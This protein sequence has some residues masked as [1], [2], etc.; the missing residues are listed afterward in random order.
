M[1]FIGRKDEQVKMRG[2]RI[3]L[4]EV[5]NTLQTQT[6]IEAAVVIAKA[7]NSGEKE[8]VAYIVS[9]TAQNIADLRA[10]LSKTLPAYMLPAHFVQLEVLPLTPNGKVDKK[11]LPEPE[12]LGITG[13]EYVAPRNDTEE[14]LAAIWQEV[15]GHNHIGVKDN[16]FEVGGHSLK[17]TRL[18]SKIYNAFEV[19]LALKDLFNYAVLEEQAS[20]IEQSSKA[21]F[22]NIPL[23]NPQP[24]YALS[25]AQRRLWV[26]SQFEEGSIAYN[27]PGVYVLEG[28]LDEAAF[29]TAFDQLI[30]RHEILRTVFKENEQGDVQQYILSPE[31]AG[32][33]ITFQDLRKENCQP[34]DIKQLV[35]A[36]TQVPFNLSAGPLMRAVLYQLTDAKWLLSFTMHHIISDGWS[37]G[38]LV[39]ELSKLYNAQINGEQL[40]LTPLSIQYKD[41]AA[42]QQQQLA[43]GQLAA[44]RA[45][46]LQQFAAEPPVLDLPSD[47][48]RP[49]VKTYNGSH[50]QL[51]VNK[52][53]QE[54]LQQLS[55]R[56]GASIFMS[57]LAAVKV[58]LYRYTWQEDLV[59]GTPVAG[60]YHHQL[61]DQV[62]F[63]VNTLA[64]RSAIKRT[65][66][67]IHVLEQVKKTTL[68][69]YTH[70]AY[71]FDQLVDELQPERSLSH[72]PLFDVMVVL[73]EKETAAATIANGKLQHLTASPF[74]VEQ[75]LSKFDLTFSFTESEEGIIADLEYNTD[76]YAAWRIE[77]YLAHFVQLLTAIVKDPQAPVG[78]IRYTSPQEEQVLLEQ[79]N[80]AAIAYPRNK[81]IHE[82]FEAQA[83]QTP[84]QVAIV[85]GNTQ[86]TYRELNEKANQLAAC[87]RDLYQVKNEEPVG[88]ITERSI[89][90]AIGMLGILK[91]GAAYV[92]VDPAHPAERIQYMLEDAGIR[93]AVIT[94][95]TLKANLNISACEQV[96]IKDNDL[97]AQFPTA[98]LPLVN[99]AGSLVYVIY[100]S[101]STGKP[102]GVQVE[103][104]SLV[105]LCYWHNRSFK[106]TADSKATV[107]SSISFDAAGWEV[108]PYLL[109]G[110]ALY[111]L[112]DE[113]R[114]DLPALVAFIQEQKITHCF[115]PTVISEKL[116]DLAPG[117]LANVQVLTGGDAL[118]NTG[119]GHL[120]LVNNYGPTENTV[121]TTSINLHNSNDPALIPIGKPIDNTQVYILDED[122]Q[123]QPIGITGEICIAGDGLARGYLNQPVL[124]AGKFIAHPF[125]PG[126][127]LYRTGDTGRW[128]PDGNIAFTG[129]KDE[130]VKIRGYRIELGEIEHTLQNHPDIETAIVLAQSL[131]E[132]GPELVAYIVA[133]AAL[134]LAELR[135]YLG[136]TLP[137]YMLPAYVMQLEQLPL[138]AS[139]KVDR[140]KLPMPAG[141]AL[142]AG[143]TYVAPRN[144]TEQELVNIWQE[145]LGRDGIGIKDNFF[146][147]G[148]HSLKA[149]RLAS[150]LYKRFETKIALKDLFKHAVLEEQASLVLQAVKNA[151]VGIT[152][153]PEQAAYTLSSA[154]RRL[155]VLSQFEEGNLA[156]N[157]AGT[158][159]FEGNLDIPALTAA[160]NALIARHESLRTT[161][162]E[163]EQGEVKQYIAASADLSITYTDVRP[164]PDQAEKVAA[165]ILQLAATLFDLRTGPLLRAVLYQVADNKWVFSFVMHH[166]I[167]DGWSMSILIRELL[168]LYHA[169]TVGAA[170]PLLP[171]RIQ[172]K[173]YAAWQQSQ[174]SEAALEPH[175]H[176][177]LQQLSGELPLLDLPG[178]HAR[179]A[180]KTYNGAAVNMLLSKTLTHGLQSLVNEQ[181]GTLF[182]G[183][184]AAV[185][186]L[187]HRYTSQEDIIIGT[188]VAGRMHSDLEDQVGLYV[189]TLAIRNQF[190][191]T[192]SYRSLLEKVKQTTLGAYEH[193]VYPFDELVD[194]LPLRRDMSRSALFDVMVILQN[195]GGVIAEGTQLGDARIS[196]YETASSRFTKFDLTFNFVE[197]AE[198]LQATIEYNRDLY[199]Q[200]T[201][202]RL[203]HHLEQLL[204][205]II[206]HPDLPLNRLNYLGAAAQLQLLE[207]FNAT[208]VVYK[209]TGT[210]LQKFEEQAAKTPEQVAILFGET[211]LSYAALNEQANQL[212]DY[213][214]TQY[215]IQANDRI[216][217]QLDR[218]E[219]T[220]IAILAVLKSGGAYVLIDTEYPQERIDYIIAD[221]QCKVVI[222]ETE[223]AKFK[224]VA[225]Q[226]SAENVNTASQPGDLAYIIYTSRS[227]GKPKGVMITHSN[228]TAFINWSQQ[229][230]N[231][232]AFDVVFAATSIC[233]DLSV[234]EIFYPLSVGKPVRFLT[235]ALAIPQYLNTAEKIL[236]NTVPSVVGNLLSE[237]IDLSNVT[238]LNMAGEPIPPRYLDQLDA[239][240][241][242]I[243]NLYGPSEDTTYSTVYR[244]KKDGDIL[245]GKP[246][247]NTRIYIL[248]EALQLQPVGVAGEI[249]IAGD[250][251]AQG[252]LNQPELT[253]AKFIDNP[254]KPG[255]RLYRTGDLGRWLSDGN[256][257]FIGR[258]DEQAKIRGYRIELGEIENALQTQTSIESAV[259][260]AK[261]NSSGEKEIVAYIVSATTQN[262]ADLRAALSKTLPAYMLPAHFVQLEV[263]PLTPNGK[264]DKKQL[265]EPEGL[266]IT[267]VEYVAPRNITEE[268]LVAIWQQVL[269]RE[270]IGV[271]D[272]FFELGGHSLKITRLAS[273]LI[274]EF[275]VKVELK[276][277]FT[278]ATPEEQAQLIQRAQK[279]AYIHIAPADKKPYYAL[280]SAQRR[281]FFLHEFAPESTG[282]NMPTV[283][284][285]GKTVD[286]QRIISVLQQLIARHESIRTSFVKIDGIA[287]QQI[288]KQVPFELEEHNC[289]PEEFNAYV[290][291]FVRPFDV[292]K[293]PLLRSS[294]VNIAGIG[295]AW[296]VDMH[297]IISDGTS[298][299][300]LIDDFLQLYNGQPLPALQLQY[301]D[302]SEWQNSILES[303]AGE[304]QKQYWLSQFA[305]GIPRLNFPASRP[306]PATFTFE[307]AV[308]QFSLGAALTTQVRQYG[309]QH[310]GT[311]QMTLLAVLNVVLHKY[312]GQ[313]DIVI[314][315]GIAGRRHPEVERIVG[316]FVNT[317]AIRNY[318]QGDKPFEAFYG[319]VMNASIGAYENQD[320][321]FE[322]LLNML[323]VEREPSRNPIFDIAMVVQNF[324]EAKAAQ[325]GIIGAGSADDFK[326]MPS[327]K[328]SGTSK[329][330]MTWFVT[331]QDED[332]IIDLEYYSA[333]YDA[334]AIEQLVSH[335]RNTLQ[336]VMLQPAITLSGIN[337]LSAKEE[338]TLLQNFA[339]GPAGYYPS[340]S[341]LHELFEAQCQ[342][343]PDN[344]AVK[345]PADNFTYRELDEKAN[346]LA[347][348]LHHTVQLQPE[349]RVGILQTRSKELLVSIFGVL[350]AG[351]AYVPLD[352][353]Y[354]EER[355]IYML[356]DAG[357]DILLVEKNLIEF[358]N[359]IQWRCKGIKHLVCIDS[360]NIHREQGTI[361]NELMRKDLWDHVGDTATDAIT[362][363]GWMS[364]YTGEYLSELEM[365][366][367]A[368]NAYLKLKAHLHPDAK[369]LEIGCSSGLTMFQV[370]PQVASYH[371]TDLSSSILAYTQQ[372]VN[373][374]GLTNIRLSCLP[375]DE[376]DRLEDGDFD[377]V[378]INSVIQSFNGH[379]YLRDVLIKVISKIKDKGLLFLGDIQDEDKREA[380]ISDLTAFKQNHREEDY[381]TK[382]DWSSELFLSR[383]Y[384]S[385]LIPD[386]IGIVAA[387]YSDKVH[388]VANELTRYRFDALLHINKQQ[389]AQTT[390]K[391]KYQHD[392]KEI[393]AQP[394][395]TLP[396]SVKPD[397]L[398]Y[399]I[400]TSGSTGKPKG[401]MVEHRTVVNYIT[402]SKNTYL[403]EGPAHF[404]LFTS[405]SFD[406]T[407]TSIF[408]P[409]LTGNSI[410]VYDASLE[411]TDLLKLQMDRKNGVDVIKLTPSHI[412]LIENIGLRTTA[413]KSAIV[414]G[415]ELRDAHISIL[416][417]LDPEMEIYNEYGPTEATVGC[418]VWKV[419]GDF[420]QILIGK[421]ITNTSI[422]LMDNEHRIVPVGVI[423][424]ICIGGEC[425][426][427]GYLNKPAL[428]AEKFVTNPYNTK[429]RIYKTGDLGRWLP[430]GNIEF[431]GRKDDQVKIRGYR[432]ELGEIESVLQSHPEIDA[433]VVVA[434]FNSN[435]E[436]ELIA[437]ITARN[438]LQ[439]GAL[440][441]Y[442]SGL[443]PVY[444]LPGHYVQLDK[445]PLTT[446]GKV[447]RKRLPD[448]EGMGLSAG[449]EYVAPQTETE[450]KLVR[451]WE[452]VLGK[453][454]VGLKDN[455]FDLGGHSLKATRLASLI[456]REFDVKVPLK[457]L[458]T[459]IIL[460]QQANLIQHTRKTAF[461]A[462]SPVTEQEHYQLSSSQRRLWVLSLFEGGNAAYNMPG[463]YVFEGQ[464]NQDAL[465]YAFNALI[466]RHEILRTIFKED[467]DGDVRQY[468][469][470]PE[471]A[472]FTI[473]YYDV[474]QEGEE[475]LRERIQQEILKPFDL[476]AGPLL[477][478]ALYQVTDHK[479]IFTH[480]MH[481]IISDG[482]SMG[483]LIKELLQLYNAY[484]K[485]KDFPL[486][487]LRIQYKDY[488]AWQQAQLTG[489]SLQRHKG[490]WL[491]QF[492][493]ELP[494]LELPA[495]K[496]RPAVKTYNS[497]LVQQ[498][499]SKQ[500]N[501]GIKSLSQAQGATLFM[502]LLTLVKALLYRYT[503]Q[504]DIIIGTPIAG[505]DHIDLENQIGFYIN[506]LA[507][508]TRFKGTD[509]YQQLLEQVQQVTL[510]AYEHQMYP[511]DGLVDELHLQRDMS[512]SALFDVMV[513]LQNESDDRQDV[514]YV[515]GL[516]ISGYKGLVDIVN[517]FDLCF[518]FMEWEEELLLNL[519][520]NSDIYD[521]ETIARLGIHL[522]NLL[523]AVIEQPAAPIYQ[524]G[525]LQEKEKQQLLIS[526]NDTV[527][528]WSADNTVVELFEEQ[529]RQT[530][531]NI[532]LVF[533]DTQL[534]YRELN[535]KANQLGNYLRQ[536]YNVHPDDL[537]GITLERS[538]QMVIAILGVL[539]SGAAYVPIDTEYPQDRIEYMITD[540]RCK[541]LLDAAEMERFAAAEKYIG[542]DLPVLHK[543][544][545]LVYVI[546]TSATTGKPK[547]A[548][549]E[550]GALAARIAYFKRSYG[551]SAG[552]NILF[553]RSFS[554]DGAIEEYLL[555]LLTGAR[556]CI[557]PMD[558]KQD[559]INNCIEYIEQY[560][561][562]KINMP[563]V[564]LGELM[565][566]ADAATLHKLSSLRHVVSGGDKLT[567]NII[568]L[569]L[570]KSKARLTNAYGPTEN[571][572]DSTYWVATEIP[573]NANVPIGKP[574]DNSQVY[575]LD[576]HLQLVPVGITGEL[577]VSGAGLARGYLNNELLT[578]EKF[579]HNP[580]RENERVYKTGDLGRW[581]PD[582]NI[583]F[584]GRGDDQVKIRGY[585]IELGEIESAL[586][587]YPDMESAVVVAKGAAD[588]D[589]DL[590]AYLVS[591][592]EINPTDIRT[593]LANT[594]PAYM[595][596]AHFVQ[597]EALP[598]NQNGKVDRK[599]L[600]D[601]AGLGTYTGAAYIAPRNETE[602]KLVLIWQELLS[603]ERI[604]VKDNFFELGGHSLKVA[605]LISRINLAFQ[606]RINIQSIFKDPT[607]ENIA[608]QISF[609]LEQNNLKQNTS[610]LIQIDI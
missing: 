460:E 484:C 358:A 49:A 23:V 330:D 334:A 375:A 229:E 183:L 48:A 21:A 383:D 495:D 95:E 385:D 274:K 605:Q 327:W 398:A 138:N 559:I 292:S 213:L 403:G 494:V 120:Q 100:T 418:V 142:T 86:L 119:N 150:Q 115:L 337:I 275:E 564:I 219:Q 293:A 255:E 488:A 491:T 2:Y 415:E 289:R 533:K 359:R 363:G 195:A 205:A 154:Q 34:A 555:P 585:R 361:R 46:W 329:F 542:T 402:W 565:Q 461:I 25:A 428:T 602:E 135:A 157:M 436:K 432:I 238:V 232:S 463:V 429:E 33:A 318:P 502:G 58:L 357:V 610:A 594:L 132:A 544:A 348:F 543:P 514:H 437:Y 185:N 197:A 8:I 36:V 336:T 93:T 27:M 538:E 113:T 39:N 83:A 128:L 379:N 68:D 427:R 4:G 586:M 278:H 191:S 298:L 516:E 443:I 12:G 78:R 409:L 19:K 5:E 267:G 130:Q 54:G 44:H 449:V 270:Q 262:I 11:K 290:S 55:Q 477:R 440:R 144:A 471:D 412:N 419:E 287:W 91:S 38:I 184:L 223:L 479:W 448:P 31:A 99:D 59:T 40:A 323:K 32:F 179:P 307:G 410:N 306:R 406:L 474:R 143:A 519:E 404:G 438:V 211:V 239:E 353:D 188:P 104:R 464:L 249:C 424:E 247:S 129:R 51:T 212:G 413:V 146:E 222:D 325:P 237:G 257:V 517:K 114:L 455:F 37:M 346:R 456:H 395:T 218:S 299:Q 151:F 61:E 506:T 160:F 159:V 355:L 339:T 153:V 18:S 472:G 310:H 165:F 596:P 181:G 127:R 467:A 97:I 408:T 530:P 490:Y 497:G 558:F 423:G 139:G 112:P 508:R 52:S 216:G 608:E 105:N 315:C 378:I 588:G 311:L 595:V 7:N 22:A 167:S 170:H 566:A 532:A 513:V 90:M 459:N 321:Q 520:Y 426:A 286:K 277:L 447:N 529:V 76:I 272:N 476:S 512:R 500:L 465:A 30:T 193:Q 177:W 16:F 163:D 501:S 457:E 74:N 131:S 567:A 345:S 226:Y 116:A 591:K 134:P 604:G 466:K 483:I 414:G 285:L 462:I 123:L 435:G 332:I 364:S 473:D 492:E 547:G 393:N 389:P 217:I 380:L 234:F 71:P 178:D 356:E 442:L 300:V 441:A 394:L 260:I 351:G 362:G 175:K 118:R 536:Q 220:I 304:S 101:G 35:Q 62:G 210:I 560:R 111:P 50:V 382:T 597:L 347:N 161:F 77:Q 15:L 505:R 276:E 60:R 82:L 366:E 509:S 152:P 14:K 584:I 387:E 42:W 20:L 155:W 305:D 187:L 103:H 407:V 164:E 253:A 81:T 377:I 581:L 173:D 482:W 244:L 309:K 569:F 283:Q 291:A 273:Q 236:I 485:H 433:A 271:K 416:W 259:V 326:Q 94:D 368:V 571:T 182:M 498:K 126:Q 575:I 539:K 172:Y 572:D 583:E 168:D 478:A 194:A 268:K 308:H 600:P 47:Y 214:R 67:F 251:L 204:A 158:Y 480:V 316:M 374:K 57:L 548:M 525:Y 320:I 573:L 324:T 386:H 294:L 312:T 250:G 265:P 24:A 537:V 599:K 381:R 43:E 266:G 434:R 446:N 399:V 391:R 162:R 451:I 201:V 577:Y 609:I 180:V 342:L 121:V 171:L 169:Y 41:Y 422:Y 258:K 264:V 343:T 84:D 1:V 607:I 108:W 174:L 206:A 331:E 553:Y 209:H 535:E 578:A 189:N 593:Q 147:L 420:R 235:N 421:Q 341:T 549:I 580:F 87:L 598:L 590:V 69:A 280:S 475:Q 102:K 190:S 80:P 425:L 208:E 431:L 552:D 333:I 70:Q 557:A 243:R 124:T 166:I 29:S 518:T 202:E 66:S 63:Y 319:E 254:F 606:V 72:H 284:Y 9:E 296:I 245:I 396:V 89:E 136:K 360:D 231:V 64:I 176:W 589:K 365:Q 562:T 303:S 350:K 523:A 85:A 263:L 148:G 281:L 563:P 198:E 110:A 417:K 540:S 554:F 248:S 390:G 28:Q 469:R 279:T 384:L 603:K 335:F 388:T 489:V 526:F 367:Y 499:F 354:P 582:G 45:Y 282:Y 528:P 203:T 65:D 221:S 493:G 439:A 92:P 215:N 601:P 125:K 186:V 314:G 369:V 521:H 373:E 328:G 481:H 531:D 17:A 541:V 522:E 156:Y 587:K 301:R 545:N 344:I 534:T 524:L 511:F 322:D 192:D 372:L 252:Y 6:G 458:F 230:F 468:I 592:T 10:N 349:E 302:F 26:L 392:I 246:I 199:N 117:E 207:T 228:A 269:S 224:Q 454:Q 106:V 53:L 75:N 140:K 200:D 496:V 297:H 576:K 340:S 317:L 88:L 405:P 241:I 109:S 546:Y 470:L 133:K 561:I 73:Q 515:D 568:R 242:E 445:L 510:G 504:E 430:N 570:S 352:T 122:L 313:D 551:I 13:V 376:I 256:I 149:T 225:D 574:V 453:D 487:P 401:V 196:S 338:Q 56:T 295:Y 507:L 79:F 107:Y 141:D 486:S 288:H 3:E 145:I 579:I 397:N 452:E 550:H 233:F 137:A 261:G 450:K 240:R 371:G 444:M 411:I 400:Y 96:V 527:Q 370:A 98:N 503:N 227:T 556:C